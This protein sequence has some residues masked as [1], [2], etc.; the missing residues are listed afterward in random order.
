MGSNRARHSVVAK[1]INVRPAT[2]QDK[3]ASHRPVNPARKMASLDNRAKAN[4]AISRPKPVSKVAGKVNAKD[5][6]RGSVRAS[7]VIV[8]SKPPGTIPKVS[9]GR[10]ANKAAGR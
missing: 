7:V 3:M 2:N 9:A 6:G 10:K 8:R 4:A 1:A 5:K